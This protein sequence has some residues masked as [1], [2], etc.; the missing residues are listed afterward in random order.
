MA[1]LTMTTA[2]RAPDLLARLRLPVELWAYRHGWAWPLAVLILCAGAALWQARVVPALAQAADLR[3][4]IAEPLAP[5]PVAAAPSA[6][7]PTAALEA[8]LAQAAPVSRQ[9][10]QIERL[11]RRHGIALPRGQYTQQVL[12]PS[13]VQEA[14]VT[15]RFSAGYPATRAFVEDLLRNL[16]NAAVERLELAR[17]S[18]EGRTAEVSLRL[19]LWRL[20]TAGTRS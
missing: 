15:L 4:R 9:M 7:A 8:V 6:P 12:R 5:V 14:H 11:A 19:A 10:Q 20:P 2:S 1:S 13:G 18:S 17:T 16:P 3:A